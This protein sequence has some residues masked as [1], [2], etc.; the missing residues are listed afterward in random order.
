MKW[1]YDVIDWLGG[2]PYESASPEEIESF[3]STR[4][5]TLQHA[6]KTRK[7]LGVFG[8]GNAEYLFTRK[9]PEIP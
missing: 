9:S 1:Y 3:F 6:F 7:R 4:G 5:F 8:T 2:Y